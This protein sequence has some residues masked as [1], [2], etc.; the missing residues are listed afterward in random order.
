M[1]W[2]QPALGVNDASICLRGDTI[3]GGV[4]EFSAMIVQTID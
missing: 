4:A 1:Q 3:V 2:W